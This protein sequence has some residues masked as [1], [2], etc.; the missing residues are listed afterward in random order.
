[1]YFL[2][3]NFTL[4]IKYRKIYLRKNSFTTVKEFTTYDLQSFTVAKQA[5]KVS[6]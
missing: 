4:S 6:I 3:Y 5:F 2:T 1:M